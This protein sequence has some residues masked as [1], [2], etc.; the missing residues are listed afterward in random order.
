MPKGPQALDIEVQRKGK[1]EDRF[2]VT[3]DLAD[4]AQ[5]RGELVK[6][7]KGN[8]WHEKRW[9]EFELLARPAGTWEKPVKV[10]T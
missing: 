5:L 10:R 7:L 3:A 4:P 9:L 8:K 2:S 6:W 1:H